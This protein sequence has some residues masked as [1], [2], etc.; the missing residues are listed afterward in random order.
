[1][2]HRGMVREKGEVYQ[3]FFLPFF[4]QKEISFEMYHCEMRTM[5]EYKD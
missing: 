2:F 4:S 3:F 5:V 1:M